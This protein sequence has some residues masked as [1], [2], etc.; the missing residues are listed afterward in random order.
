MLQIILPKTS[1]IQT[2]VFSQF[3]GDMAN[4]KQN[5]LECIEYFNL[6]SVIS[7]S[8]HHYGCG[9]PVVLACWNWSLFALGLCFV[10]DGGGD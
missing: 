2:K 7:R 3:L 6:E 1:L 4:T 8:C 5:L 9:Q 10:G